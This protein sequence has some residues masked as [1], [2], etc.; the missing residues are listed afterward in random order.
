MLHTHANIDHKTNATEAKSRLAVMCHRRD[1]E[2][3][4]SPVVDPGFYREGAPTPEVRGITYYLARFF[5]ENC[6]KK[7]I[8]TEVGLP[9]ENL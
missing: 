5:V 6:M 1:P 2:H 7:K 9:C 3:H 8:L 4:T